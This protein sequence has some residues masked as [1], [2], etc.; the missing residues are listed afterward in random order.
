M[1]D[2]HLNVSPNCSEETKEALRTALK[3]AASSLSND[4]LSAEPSKEEILEGWKRFAE[5]YQPGELSTE[6]RH[7][8]ERA[9]LMERQMKEKSFILP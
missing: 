6:E 7:Q 8:F 5:T 1:E 3:L 9:A 2:I 4:K